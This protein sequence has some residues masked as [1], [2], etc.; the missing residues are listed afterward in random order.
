M[1]RWFST[2]AA[3]ARS[4][5]TYHVAAA[6]THAGK[7]FATPRLIV[8]AEEAARVEVSGSAGY[9]LALTVLPQANDEIRVLADL[10][11]PHGAMT[12]ELL[13]QPG[14]TTRVSIGE[15][16]LELTVNPAQP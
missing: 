10:A 4:P 14:R 11:S 1:H 5:D 8:N 15:L 9:T 3:A 7:S 2:L 12:P 6:L 13:V 16:G